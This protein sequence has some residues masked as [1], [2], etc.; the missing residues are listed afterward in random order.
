[1]I[2]G[3]AYA[4]DNG[5]HPHVTK[6]VYCQCISEIKNWIDIGA[7]Q[8]QLMTHGV[9]ITP[10]DLYNITHGMC[11]H[12]YVYMWLIH[13]MYGWLGSECLE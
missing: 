5:D 11:Y 1:M 6:E 7:M 13:V 12:M 4:T 3:A 10:D 9:I 2:N 8:T